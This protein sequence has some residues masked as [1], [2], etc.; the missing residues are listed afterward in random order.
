[1]QQEALCGPAQFNV[2]T[3]VLAAGFAFEAYNEPAE[4]DGSGG[5]RGPAAQGCRGRGQGD[6]G[7][8]D[9]RRARAGGEPA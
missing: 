3:A 1:M 9:G 2:T 6:A 7:R 8:A 5:G 4:Q